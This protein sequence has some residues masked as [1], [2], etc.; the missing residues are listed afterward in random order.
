MSM[1]GKSEMAERV[2]PDQ[3]PLHYNVS[4]TL[5]DNNIEN[6]LGGKTA[7]YFQD[8]TI[9]YNQL[10]L[11]VN[12][13]GNLLKAEFGVMPEA[14]VA[15][16]MFD[17]PEFVSSFL[18]VIRIGAVAV[19]LST[20]NSPADYA[21][22]LNDTRAA[23]LIADK[24]FLNVI[25]SI[26]QSLEY[27]KCVLV[28]GDEDDDAR[29]VGIGRDYRV[30][31]YRESLRSQSDLLQA[32]KTNKNDAAFWMYTSGSTGRPKGTV[33]LQHDIYY[34]AYYLNQYFYDISPG[35]LLYSASKLFF[36]YG[37]GNSL[38]MPFFSGAS[39]V[40]ENQRS[41][42]EIVVSNIRKRKPTKVFS[43]P[44][45]YKAVYEHLAANA[46]WVEECQSVQ[47]YYSAGEVLG[48]NLY[49]KWLKLTG[50]EILTVLGSTE[51]LQGYIGALPGM[52]NPGC[53]GRIIPGYEARIVDEQGYEVKG[54]EKGVLMIRGDS[55]A[56][57]YW[58][59]HRESKNT[60]RGEW[61]YTGDMVYKTE[62]EIFWFVGRNDE[63]IKIAGLWVSPTEIEEVLAAHPSI[64]ECAVIA[65]DGD[66][67]LVTMVAYVVCKENVSADASTE[68]SMQDFLKSR[69]P[70]YKCP[71]TMRFVK[72]LPRNP[73]GKLQRFRLKEMYKA[74]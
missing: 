62:D 5:L 24:A 34:A 72:E 64:L 18:A 19:P 15:L 67:E 66:D 13:L 39:V 73:T 22:M 60:F 56:S 47:R 9:T 30:L 17:C 70:T 21:Y 52:G 36:A 40:L 45:I 33:H 42:P 53:L 63:M 54:Q 16:L 12:R 27:L 6:G 25:S 74:S 58:N 49:D 28:V 26:K 69:L 2:A 61:S 32:A 43:V 44:T 59:R 65:I 46:H 7:I 50:R 48:K 37:L 4:Q 10:S 41:T 3:L 51:A 68:H 55:I 38:W 8:Q 31:R 35:D 57:S 1:N 14:R 29:A 11:E 71:R 23:V 20:L